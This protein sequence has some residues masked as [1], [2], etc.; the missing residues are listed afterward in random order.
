MCDDYFYEEMVVGTGDDAEDE[1]AIEALV[2][3]LDDATEASIYDLIDVD[4]TPDDPRVGI[5]YEQDADDIDED[6]IY[7]SLDMNT[8]ATITSHRI[9]FLGTGSVGIVKE[10]FDDVFGNDVEL[11]YTTGS[12]AG[13]TKDPPATSDTSYSYSTSESTA[14]ESRFGANV[15]TDSDALG[16]YVESIMNDLTTEIANTVL[17]PQ[18][19]FKKVKAEILDE[20]MLSTFETTETT[21]TVTTGLTT[22][23]EVSAEDYESASESY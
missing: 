2:E 14:L 7:D 21:Q 12:D 18:Y 16:A 17:M 13:P 11:Y 6:G 1:E 23:V 20:S 9:Q 4:F 3:S 15:S 10:S 22:T 8:T 5:Y 19:T